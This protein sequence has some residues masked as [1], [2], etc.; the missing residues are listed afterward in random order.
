LS[1]EEASAGVAADVAG[2]HMHTAEDV[3]G[4]VDQCLEKKKASSF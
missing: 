4:L 2:R 3:L 1:D